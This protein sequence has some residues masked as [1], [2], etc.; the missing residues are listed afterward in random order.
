MEPFE[1]R[2]L[3]DRELDA[4][5]REW[6]APSVPAHLRVSIFPETG[7]PW[8]QRLWTASIRI[9]VPVALMLA[10]LLAAVW[11]QWPVRVAPRAFVQTERV[12]VQPVSELR[13]KII[14]RVHVPK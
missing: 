7:R 12:E 6:D 2:Q 1:E 8:W 11:W 9:P 14:R 3:S 4:L 13:P 10:M 5:L